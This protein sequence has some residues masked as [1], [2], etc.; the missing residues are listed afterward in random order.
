[1]VRGTHEPLSKTDHG[2]K[3]KPPKGKVQEIQSNDPNK[4]RDR[5]AQ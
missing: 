2:K 3:Y 5:D 4:A 1:M